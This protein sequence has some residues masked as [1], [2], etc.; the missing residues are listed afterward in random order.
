MRERKRSYA[1]ITGGKAIIMHI[2]KTTI[3]FER[4]GNDCWVDPLA[5]TSMQSCRGDGYI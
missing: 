1:L 4:E 2:L 3:D 5:T